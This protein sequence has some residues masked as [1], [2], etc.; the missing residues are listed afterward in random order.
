M[1]IG[2]RASSPNVKVHDSGQRIIVSRQRKHL[3]C[4]N[5]LHVY[6]RGDRTGLGQLPLAKSSGNVKADFRGSATKYSVVR[7]KQ[8][9]RELDV[10][11][12]RI[13]TYSFFDS[14]CRPNQYLE[15][16]HF[17]CPGNGYVGRFAGR[18]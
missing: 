17:K 14:L 4:L 3:A 8:T 6:A 11:N 9:W 10:S 2:T 12:Q 5:L 15:I 16:L 13:P 1:R 18:E 7:G